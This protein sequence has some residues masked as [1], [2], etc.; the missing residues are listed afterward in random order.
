MRIVFTN[1]MSKFEAESPKALVAY[2]MRTNIV[3]AGM[4]GQNARP[5]KTRTVTQTFARM[6]EKTKD[7][8]GQILSHTV[9]EERITEA[10][11]TY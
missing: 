9:R 8:Q 7:K 6:E 11:E 10:K 5:I 4:T 3:Q 1:T 2:P